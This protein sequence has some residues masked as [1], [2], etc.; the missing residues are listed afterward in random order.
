[1]IGRFFLPSTVSQIAFALDQIVVDAQ[2]V[3][4]TEYM[5]KGRTQDHTCPSNKVRICIIGFDKF[6]NL[7]IV[8]DCYIITSRFDDTSFP[9]FFYF[10]YFCCSL[11]DN[12]EATMACYNAFP[13][14]LLEDNA[15]NAYL[16]SCA[17]KFVTPRA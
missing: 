15:I 12:K 8:G 3:K 2:I 1:M 9:L 14:I 16:A 6:S 17:C 13:G 10:S 11:Y 4:A 5:S 7:S